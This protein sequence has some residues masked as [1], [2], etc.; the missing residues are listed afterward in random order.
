[1]ESPELASRWAGNAVLLGADAEAADVTG[2][3]LADQY[4]QPPRWYHTAD[5]ACRVADAAEEL[6][7][8]LGLGARERQTLTAAALAHD[9][10]YEG[11]PGEDEDASAAAAEQA[12]LT[13]RVDAG[14]ARE[15]ARLIRTTATH[16]VGDDDLAGA[17]LA[18]AD[19]AVLGSSPADYDRYAV[20]VRREYARI[21]DE[22][23][24]QGRAAVLGDLLE[25]PALFVTEPARRRWEQQARRNMTRELRRYR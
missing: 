12:L 20:D 5:H 22:D 10:V 19:L 17:V 4:E 8:G 24:R 6:A 1:M 23:W 14:P 21:S 7:V 18:D 11:R 13:A 2:R 15:V 25:R 3:R 9:V 16:R